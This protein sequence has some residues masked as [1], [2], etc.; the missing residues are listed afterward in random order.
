MSGADDAGA[1]AAVA[2][3]RRSSSGSSARSRW[4]ARS[5]WCSPQRRALGAVAGR[6][7]CSASASSTSSRQAPFLGVV[8]IIV[9]TGAIMMLFLFVLML[10]G[11]DSSDSRRRD[12]ARP[13]G[14]RDRARP[15]LRRRWSA[16]ASPGRSQDQ[17][18]VGLDE[19]NAATATSTA[20]P[21][22]LFTKYVFAFEVTSALLITAAVGAMV[23]G[24][25]RA[26]APAAGAARGRCRGR[27]S[28]PAGRSRCPARASSPRA[29]SV[30][31]PAL[32][33][34][35]TVAERVVAD[36]PRAAGARPMPRPTD[37]ASSAAG[38][39]A[40]HARPARRR[41]AGASR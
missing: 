37:A 39:R 33:P 1:A 25:H 26:R 35:G 21:E 8:Q 22:L 30:A 20:S 14:R 18:A 29:N 7:R 19:A 23:L 9:Y 41:T 15:R 11:R 13:A 27:G 6:S 12:A 10:V 2:A 17:P 40:R 4:S 16:P 34:D 31:A 5:A 3:A 36:R 32:L 24:A 28:A 38:R